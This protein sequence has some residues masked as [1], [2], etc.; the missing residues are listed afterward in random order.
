MSMLGLE[1]C[2]KQ[3]RQIKVAAY[4]VK[5]ATVTQESANLR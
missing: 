3:T 5:Y 2:V 1:I 4:E